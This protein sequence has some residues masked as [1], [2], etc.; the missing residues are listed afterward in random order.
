MAA[1]G[2]DRWLNDL[3]NHIIFK[4]VR[5]R[6]DADFGTNE[7]ERA[8]NLTFCL[9]GDFFLWDDPEGVFYTTNLRQLNSAEPESSGKYQTL[10]CINPPLFQV[11]HVLLSCQ[12]IAGPHRDKQKKQPFMHTLTPK[13][14]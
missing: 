8:K 6:L 12:S 3:P 13:E 1:F 2:T 9:G 14:N 10:Q 7:R 5:E 4:K 11:R